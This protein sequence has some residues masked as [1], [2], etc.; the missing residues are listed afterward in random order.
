MDSSGQPSR[1]AAQRRRGRRLRAAFWHE[2]QSIGP[3]RV[4]APFPRTEDGQGR[5]VGARDELH[6]HD[7]GPPPPPHPSRSSS[8]SLKKSPAGRGRTGSLPC[9]DRRS[10]FCQSLWC[11]FSTILRRRW[12]NSC[13]TCSSSSTRSCLIPSWLSKCQRSCLR[14]F[15]CAPWCAIRSWRNSWWKCR[16]LYP[17]PC[18]SGLGSRTLAF[19][20]LVVEGES[21]VFKVFPLDRVQQH[22]L[23]LKNVFL[24]GL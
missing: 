6:G 20:F 5:C 23:L 15:L 3:G 8:A 18:C 16:R 21:L 9:P 11:H 2:R 12:W 17:F 24:S 7:P 22:C 10:G 19:Q 13:Q 4:F 14:T 1:S